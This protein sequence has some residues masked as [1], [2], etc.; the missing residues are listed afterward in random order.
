MRRLSRVREENY[1]IE[2]NKSHSS[3]SHTREYFSDAKHLGGTSDAEFCIDASYFK[4]RYILLFDD[5]ITS[6]ASMER[7][8]RT[9]ESIGAIV[10]GGISIG[11]TK[12][13]RQ[14]NHPINLLG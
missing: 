10:I 5:V 9:L 6:G 4:D 11:K 8:K 7:F 14:L 2:S 12:H 3:R 13:E 1:K